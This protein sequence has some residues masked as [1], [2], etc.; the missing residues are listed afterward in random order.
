ML[1]RAICALDNQDV[2]LAVSELRWLQNAVF[3]STVVSRV[4]YLDAIDLNEE[5]G[6]AKYVPRP[7]GRELDAIMLFLLMEVDQLNLVERVF[8]I[9]LVE[10]LLLRL[11]D[12]AHLDEILEHEVVNGLCWVRHKYFAI[13]LRLFD[14]VGQSCAVVDV[15]MRDEQ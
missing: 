1:G 10:Q 11:W 7:E 12:A 4:K 9:F 5:H 2:H 15:E 13:E 14:E 3:F 6:R 8:N